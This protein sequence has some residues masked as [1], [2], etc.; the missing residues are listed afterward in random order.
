V[1]SAANWQERECFDLMGVRF[2]GHPDLRRIMLPDD[3]VGHPLRKDYEEQPDYHGIPTT[4]PNPLELLKVPAPKPAPKPAEAKEP[5][6]QKEPAPKKE[7]EAT[8][9]APAPV[10]EAKKEPAAEKGSGGGDAGDPEPKP[11]GG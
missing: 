5:A 3:W 11:S 8:K 10:P 6:A 1:W 4:R 7:P 2:E 9:P